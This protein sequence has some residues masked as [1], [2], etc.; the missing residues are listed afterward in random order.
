MTKKPNRWMAYLP[1]CLGADVP[2]VDGLEI[3]KQTFFWDGSV[4]FYLQRRTPT[5]N[6]CFGVV[7]AREGETQRSAICRLVRHHLE[8]IRKDG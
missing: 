1:E 7:W 5:R 8:R 3:I 6:E 2:L 4:R